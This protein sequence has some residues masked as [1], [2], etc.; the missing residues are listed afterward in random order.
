MF[1]RVL[2]AN[3]G[4]IALR[5]IRACR[6]MGIES[7]AVYSQA[8]EQSL[9]VALADEAVC[10]GPAAAAE[11]YLRVSNILAAAEV[12]GAD[13]I[14]P[15]YGFLAENADFAAM[16]AD[17]RIKFIGPSPD[18]ITRM[19]DKNIARETMRSAGV[20]V[21]PGSQGIVEDEDAALGVARDIGYP[22]IVKAV[23]GGGGKG[24]RV[25][26]NDAGVVTAFQ[27]AS[28]EAERAFSNAA[29][30]IEK[31]IERA[32]H[33]EVQILAD[34]HGHVVHLGERDCSIQ[35]RHQKLVEESPSPAIDPR[36]RK[37]LGDASLKAAKA[38]GYA[39]AGTVEFL[40][41]EHSKDFHFMEMNTRIQ[42][43]HP[44]SEIV[45]GVDLIK[46]QLRVA[47]GEALGYKQRDIQLRGH[48]IEFRVNA[49][50]PARDFA[51]CPGLIPW[52][53]FPG[54]PGVRVDSSVYAN[55]FIPPYYDSMIA[56]LITFG[57]DR[58]E[59]IARMRRA[60]HEFRLEEIRSTIPLGHSLMRDGCFVRGEYDTR[61][62]DQF[63]EDWI[64]D[65]E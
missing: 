65:D 36:T 47:T 37:R 41:D 46:E 35:R 22:V 45:S 4:E 60:L 1:E 31:Y 10:I 32:R 42:V 2:I 51:P 54:G 58:D 57:K 63:M 16:C 34:E 14:H 43:E 40:Y 12:T 33:V 8:D 7:V 50:D 27:L 52:V 62:L 17:A 18:A 53:N 56:K 29:L 23:A 9:H 28:A 49:E 48:A 13:A 39:N 55:Y 24:M 3:R 20:P 6:E 59:A 38:V 26:H 44:V 15:G 30:Y 19:G 61:Y 25:A 64:P 11:S 21:T 5:V